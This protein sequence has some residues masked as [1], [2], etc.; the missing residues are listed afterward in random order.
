MHFFSTYLPRFSINT[1]LVHSCQKKTTK[2]YLIQQLFKGKTQGLFKVC[3]VIEIP[4]DCQIKTLL[5]LQ[6]SENG[7]GETRVTNTALLSPQ[8]P[9]M[10][11]S[12]TPLKELRSPK[13]GSSIKRS[14]SERKARNRNSLPPPTIS[15][16]V[17][18]SPDTSFDQTP[19][20]NN[21]RLS[22][23]ITGEVNNIKVV[24]RFRPHNEN[25][26]KLQD[27]GGLPCVQFLDQSSLLVNNEN[28]T[29][30]RIFDPQSS[31]RDIFD[32]SVTQTVDDLF[33]GYN[34]T[35]LAYGQTG[36]G[37]SY[38]MMG[39]SI[40]DED[41]K[42]I[43]PRIADAIFE[44]IANGDENIEFTLSVSY[45][46]IYMEMIRDLL[47]TDPQPSNSLSIQEDKTN[48]VHVR[49]LSKIYISSSKEL[50]SVLER[51]SDLRVTSSTEMNMESSR[52]HAIFQLNLTQINQS[53]GSTKRSKLFLVDLAGS[54]KVGKTGA[55]GQTLE[56]AKKI[57]SSL[58]SLGNV[59]NALTD[60]KSTYIP[61]RD[62]KLTRILQESLG[63]N[64]RTSLIINCSPSTFNVQETISTL[65][66][67]TRAKKIKNKAHVNNEPSGME[68]MKQVENLKKINEE[69]DLRNKELELELELWKSGA[70][71]IQKEDE[72][73]E[74]LSKEKDFKLQESEK[75]ITSLN[76]RLSRLTD[77][78]SQAPTV[79]LDSGINKAPLQRQLEDSA[80]INKSLM[81][82]L[83]DKCNK[84]IEME[85]KIDE[86]EDKLEKTSFRDQ[87][88]EERKVFALEKTLEKFSEK[89]E[90]LEVQNNLLKRD[91]LT[92]K[93]I[94][95]TRNERI[96]TL[97]L[98]VKDQQ[99]QVHK[100]SANFES[101]L[102]FL[103]DRLISVK[104]T[105]NNGSNSNIN[106]RNF[107]NMSQIDEMDVFNTSNDSITSSE[108]NYHRA[109]GVFL[110]RRTTNSSNHSFNGRVGLNLHIVKPIRGGGTNKETE[111]ENNNL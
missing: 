98:M 102:S 36:S 29:F 81:I 31:Q 16:P 87:E 25:E 8:S 72:E 14:L 109:D 54:E 43:I 49:N 59:I 110:S 67:G 15:L 107:S 85:L 22:K 12:S 93:K 56:E 38:T 86:L 32:F 23:R 71:K 58:S 66:F 100:E 70:S 37:K 97:E 77:I 53:D 21:N 111:K 91:V 83:E 92:T 105:S 69:Q 30:D 33:N 42:G 40:N 50:Y 64:S 3:L 6:G 7:I 45:M 27:E 82:D 20:K 35:V 5:K 75:V 101:K 61:Y 104:K 51:G 68:L 65:R 62:S 48:G 89:L 2:H 90:E 78:L 84:M 34:G 79:Q 60:L 41:K 52:S 11:S 46:E 17:L 44:K 108:F 80:F 99:S 1:K 76:E 18:A 24:A 94:S 39:S 96:K 10:S 103:K 63:G 88:L 13:N 106:Q 95:E 4:S 19:V 74:Q 9:R 26:I 73:S 47:T 55:S 57:N 28:Y